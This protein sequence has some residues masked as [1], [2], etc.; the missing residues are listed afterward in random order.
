MVRSVPCGASGN[1]GGRERFCSLRDFGREWIGGHQRSDLGETASRL[2]RPFVYVPQP[3]SKANIEAVGKGDVDLA[4]GPI[5]IT[6]DRPPTQKSISSAVFHG[7][8]GLMIPVRLPEPVVAFQSFGWAA[9]S[10]LGGLMVLLF[11]VGNL[12]GWLSDGAIRNI[13][14]P[15]SKR[16]QWDVVALV[17]SPQS[18]MAI[19]LHLQN[20]QNDCWRLDV[21]VIAGSVIDHGGTSFGIHGFVLQPEP[22][23]RERSICA[24]KRWLLWLEPRVKL[25]EFW[26][27]PKQADTLP[28][29]P[30][31][32]Q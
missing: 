6:H 4:I 8:E 11:V 19:G 16:W 9:L 3:N 31:R 26:S 7:Q 27:P 30:C 12:I 5:S 32:R 15:C 21:D 13:S 10:S 1:R 29:L 24:T 20:R 28:A 2:D 25:G 22:S 23:F 14:S 18:V 17:P